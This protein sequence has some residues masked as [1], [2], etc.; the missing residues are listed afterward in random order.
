LQRLFS[1]FPNGWPG[2]GLLVLRIASGAYLL[3]N[4]ITTIAVS[5]A[6]SL[7]SLAFASTIPGGLLLIGLWTPVVGILTALLEALMIL[8]TIE[9]PKEGILLICVCAA[10]AMLGPGCWS[11]DSVLFGR[12]RLDV[13]DE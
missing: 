12:R 10:I 7:G 3:T 11:I 8:K 4:G 6:S 5:G 9:E 13:N 1:I 2:A